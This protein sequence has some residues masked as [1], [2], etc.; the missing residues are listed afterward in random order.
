MLLPRIKVDIRFRLACF[1]KENHGA[2]LRCLLDRKCGG[3]F[4]CY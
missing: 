1:I 2:V 4:E 3:T